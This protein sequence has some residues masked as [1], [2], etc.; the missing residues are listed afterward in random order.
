[1]EVNPDCSFYRD[2]SPQVREAISD[3][4]RVTYNEVAERHDP[5]VGFN[6]NTFSIGIYHVA[7]HQHSLLQ[8][9]FESLLSVVSRNPKYRVRVGEY[10]IACHKVGSASGDNIMTAFP[11]ANSA[12]AEMV[13]PIPPNQLSLAFLMSTRR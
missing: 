11:R 8:S 10:T 7:A 13:P 3:K 5:A 12:A 4:L 9:E 2:F 6:E 1:M